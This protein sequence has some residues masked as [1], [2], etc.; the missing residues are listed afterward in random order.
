MTSPVQGVTQDNELGRDVRV[1]FQ[2]M[3]PSRLVAYLAA[4]PEVLERLGSRRGLWKV[5][6]VGA[7]D[8]NRVLIVESPKGG[9]CAKQALPGTRLTDHEPPLPPE[10]AAFEEAAL[11]LEARFAPRRVPEIIHYDFEQFLIV[12]E[13]LH[14]HVSLREGL[15]AGQRFPLLAEQIADFLARTLFFSSDLGMP[16][17]EKRE[18]VAYFC[19]NLEPC[20]LREKETFTEPYIANEHVT[21]TSPQLDETV[22]LIRRDHDLKRAIAALELKFMAEPQALL[23]G[24]LN[25]GSIMVTEHDTRVIDPAFATFGPMG[26]D[27]GELLAALLVAYFAHDGRDPSHDVDDEHPAWLLETIEQVWTGFAERF[28]RLWR[29]EQAGDAF[30]RALFEGPDGREA[31]ERAQAD[32]LRQVFVDGLRFAGAAMVR[33]TIGRGRAPELLEIGDVEQ[34]ARCERRVL[35]LARELIKDA[36]YVTDIAE[37]TSVAR[38]VRED[39]LGPGSPD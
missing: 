32:Y 30:S 18:R 9:V 27:L 10:R 38:Q 2:E 13:R 35:F 26:F 33:Q 25:T 15:K 5:R 1:G 19:A 36:H 12:T 16:K 17:T 34:R 23:H 29:E 22:A 31:L 7:G 3:T 39:R 20:L 4:I 14:P 21:W 24:N 37:V 11:T 8:P 28:V 6:E